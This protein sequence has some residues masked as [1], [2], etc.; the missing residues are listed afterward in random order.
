[1]GKNHLHEGDS[2][3]NEVLNG[4]RLHQLFAQRAVEEAK[5]NPNTHPAVFKLLLQTVI[6]KN[7]PAL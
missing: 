3:I 5:G 2:R 7:V 6:M 4:G 1:M